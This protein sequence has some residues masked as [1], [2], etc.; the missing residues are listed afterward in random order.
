MDQTGDF[1]SGNTTELYLVNLFVLIP[2]L[3]GKVV[4][5][6]ALCLVGW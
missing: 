3:T 6:L 1:I 4:F 5:V 2:F